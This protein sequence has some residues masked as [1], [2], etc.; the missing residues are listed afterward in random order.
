MWP[1]TKVG[2]CSILLSVL[3]VVPPQPKR[4]SG[5]PQERGQKKAT[6][7]GSIVEVDWRLPARL[8]RPVR[9][10]LQRQRRRR[11]QR[12]AIVRFDRRPLYTSGN[13][14][15][16]TKSPV[17]IKATGVEQHTADVYRENRPRLSSSI[18]PY[19]GSFLRAKTRPKVTLVNSSGPRKNIQLVKK[20]A[21]QAKPLIISGERDV[22]YQWDTAK[23]AQEAT[24]AVVPARRQFALPLHVSLWPFKRFSSRA[25]LAD[26]KKVQNNDFLTQ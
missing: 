3:D 2:A 21:P 23:V 18:P 10:E 14:A 5:S 7:R 15:Q 17:R 20:P 13:Q 8:R 16:A 6:A 22:P 1:C 26:K 24:A 12:E 19:S 4:R 11:Q 25:P 9:Q